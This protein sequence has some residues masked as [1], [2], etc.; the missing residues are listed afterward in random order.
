MQS[1]ITQLITE[2]GSVL[3]NNKRTILDST[4]LPAPAEKIGQALLVALTQTQDIL[5]KESLRVGFVTL[6]GFLPLSQSEKLAVANWEHVQI[7]TDTQGSIEL[8]EK[9]ADFGKVYIDLQKKVLKRQAA[10]LGVLHRFENSVGG[11]IV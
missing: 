6:G 7:P 10:L 11:N 4:L 2:Y 9:L 1:S 3:Q 5:Q 8:V